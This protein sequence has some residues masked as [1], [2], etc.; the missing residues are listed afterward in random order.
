MTEHKK[1]FMSIFRDR[2][3]L[4]TFSDFS[5]KLSLGVNECSNSFVK[6]LIGQ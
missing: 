3:T 5:D 2:L 1:S 6:T 4:M